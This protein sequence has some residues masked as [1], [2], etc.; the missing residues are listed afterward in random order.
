MDIH[1]NAGNGMDNKESLERWADGEIRKT[2]E[3]FSNEVRRVEVHLSDVNG[4]K[5]GANDKRCTIEAHINQHAN[6]AVTHDAPTLEEALRGA[7]SKMMRA[8]D[9]QIG[10][11]RATRDRTTI[12]KD[13]DVL[14]VEE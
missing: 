1:I 6:V 5:G 4:A 12:R 9:S 8:L 14:P 11:M 10:K 2:L 13:A 3:R 7:D